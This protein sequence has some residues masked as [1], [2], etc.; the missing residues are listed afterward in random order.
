MLQMPEMLAVIEHQKSKRFLGE[1]IRAGIM[2]QE[3]KLW[4]S[5]LSEAAC[6]KE[7][8]VGEPNILFC[9]MLL[10]IEY[11]CFLVTCFE[12]VFV[13]GWVKQIFARTYELLDSKFWGT[14]PSV[15]PPTKI[16]FVWPTQPHICSAAY[17]QIKSLSLF[18][19]LTI[20]L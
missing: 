17:I 3:V 7:I 16:E 12:T 8:R 1:D 10:Y 11:S 9:L 4:A 6:P 2:E 13:G 5:E 19:T 20:S 14:P 18:T 15:A